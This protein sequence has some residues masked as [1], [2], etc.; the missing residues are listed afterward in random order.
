MKLSPD[1][2]QFLIGVLGT[3]IGVGLTF[4]LSGLDNRNRKE[5][6][7]RLT[8]IMVIHDIDNTIEILKGVKEAEVESDKLFQYVLKR[9]DSLETVPNDTLVRVLNLLTSNYDDFTFDTSKENIFNSDFDSWQNIGSMKF[10]DN[11]QSFFFQRKKLQDLLNT[12]YFKE[13][14]SPE[15]YMPIV[16]SMGW[17]TLDVY[18]RGI[19]PFLKEKLSDSRVVYFTNLSSERIKTYNG[20]IDSWTRLNEENK[21]IIG[22]TDR[23]LEDYVSSIANNGKAVSPAL[24]AGRWE[25]AREDDNTFLYDFHRDKTFD[26]A[27][28]YSA[29]SHAEYWSGRL[30]ATVSHSG[31]WSIEA[32]SLI[33]NMD[34]SK[35]DLQLDISGLVARENRQDSLESW[36][37]NYRESTL[38]YYSS[39]KDRMS[40]TAYKARLDPSHDKMEWTGP[41]GGA[42]Y[43]KRKD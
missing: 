9:K 26:L 2:K 28:N 41:E 35:V 8:A 32:D 25:L 1:W 7:Q 37:K 30:K 29:L 18:V 20:Y 3:A 38:E 23:E 14:I 4:F 13:P 24:L 12:D 43:L 19:R 27:I 33:L 36:A 5:H 6:A 16:R 21:F 17:V 39:N 15:E 11:V 10:I 22:I 40:H 31:T 42:Q 34:P